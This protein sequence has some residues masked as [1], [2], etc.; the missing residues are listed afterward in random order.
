MP[1]SLEV[2][3]RSVNYIRPLRRYASGEISAYGIRAVSGSRL[4]V[5]DVTARAG[6]GGPGTSGQTP[7]Q[8]AKGPDGFPGGSTQQGSECNSG[9]GGTQENT[10]A[11]GAGG[12]AT[13]GRGA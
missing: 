8:G 1:S 7:G 11:G 3:E 6:A 4:V 9:S 5:A 13:G 2:A 10:G 12:A